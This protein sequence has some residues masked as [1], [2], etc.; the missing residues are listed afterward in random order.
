MK[1]I[2]LAAGNGTR[3]R[4]LTTGLAKSLLPVFDKPMFYYP[5]STLMLMGIDDIL[6]IVS[7]DMLKIFQSHFNQGEDLG[8]RIQYKVQFEPKGLP[9]AF[10]LGSD[11]I[12][13]DGVTLILGD[14]LLYGT[15]LGRNLKK[16]SS[17]EG[18]SITVHQVSNPQDYGVVE[19]DESDKI[20]YLIEKP[21]KPNSN[22][23]IPGLYYFDNSVIERS[24]NLSP[25]AR[26][27]LEIVDLLTSY[28]N[29]GKLS[30]IKLERGTAW[31]DMGNPR[32]MLEASNFVSTIQD[33]Q[34]L[35]IGDPYEVAWHNKWIANLNFDKQSNSLDL[36]Y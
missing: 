14:N 18:A 15:G 8:I 30:H 6:I 1:G 12:G 17:V 19:F 4:P 9:D 34:G 23:A 22:W 24:Q 36:K 26:G 31:L 7:P 25:S 16:I 28:L 33:R 5:L 10:L 11:F 29:E 3:L 2:I 21:S 32:A 27:E 13:S 35:P 20:K